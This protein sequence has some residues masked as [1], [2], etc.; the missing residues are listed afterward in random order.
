LVR[1][2][3]IRGPAADPTFGPDAGPLGVALNA[4]A[5]ISALFSV[6]CGSPRE[7]SLRE[8]RAKCFPAPRSALA[9]YSWLI[10]TPGDGR[11]DVPVDSSL[12]AKPHPWW[13]IRNARA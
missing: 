7:C 11:R 8:N 10:G 13:S 4:P 6:C 12:V 2:I 5:D 9:P 1:P 3:S